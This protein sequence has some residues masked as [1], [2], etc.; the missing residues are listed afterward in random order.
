MRKPLGNTVVVALVI[1]TSAW[2]QKKVGDTLREVTRVRNMLQ[3]RVV[4]I[5]ESEKGSEKRSTVGR[6]QRP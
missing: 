1:I 5:R 3:P 4:K 6:Y 2:G